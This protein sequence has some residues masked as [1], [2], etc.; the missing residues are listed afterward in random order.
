[1]DQLEKACE[2]EGAEMMDPKA[3]ENVWM[4]CCPKPYI[5]CKQADM[6]STC[7][8]TIK[9]AVDKSSSGELDQNGLLEVRSQLLGKEPAC[10]KFVHQDKKEAECGK[11]PKEHPE[12]M[13]EMLTWQWEEL[14]DGNKPE[15]D[16][17][18]CPMNKKLQAKDGNKRK[19]QK[20]SFDPRKMEL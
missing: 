4:C 16:Q 8:A 3:G 18:K 10:A 9:A 14:G 13:C 11:W 20:L 2:G 17:F 6:S 19:S 12:M 7:V 1:L 5:Q 15:F